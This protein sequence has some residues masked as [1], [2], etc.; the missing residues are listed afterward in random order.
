MFDALTNL[1][2]TRPAGLAAL[3]LP[4]LLLLTHRARSRPMARATGTLGLWR[5]L[6]GLPRRDDERLRRSVPPRLWLLCAALTLGAMALAGPRQG[7]EP[8]GRSWTVIVDRSPSMYLMHGERTRIERALDLVGAAF[9]TLLAPGDEV[10]WVEFVDGERRAHGGVD[11][12]R[13]WL[14]APVVARPAPSWKGLDAS[15]LFWLSDGRPD[16]EPTRAGWVAAGGPAVP[17][18]V[19]L[20]RA[21]EVTWDGER[22]LTG[23]ASG[24]P[25]TLA[26]VPPLAREVRDLAILWAQ[27]R[28]L[29]VTDRV[30]AST[31]LE[32]RGVAGTASPGVRVGRDGWGARALALEAPLTD[33]RGPL[34]AWLAD[35][36]RRV[37]FGP[38]R[39]VCALQAFELL[40][41]DA[42]A[43][44]VSWSAL[45]DR[46]CLP[47]AGC[48][49]IA[50]RRGAGPPGSAFPLAPA[51]SR[52]VLEARLPIDAW[53][54]VCALLAAVCALWPRG[55]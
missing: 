40:T 1:E 16:P 42:A 43:F 38:G 6:G 24:A 21:G 23:P 14:D 10:E 8:A 4:V 29:A 12:P 49:P 39:V 3:V 22:L 44:A 54:A 15:G 13:A 50:E 11:A 7:R 48:V 20:T 41:G 17:G 26:V 30:L 5:D 45:L 27:E 51:P 18:R 33:A 46:A 36:L 31:L 53:L 25:P 32:L 37:V 52:R 34:A 55:R 35:D 19:G 9:A 47:P 28:G 2:W